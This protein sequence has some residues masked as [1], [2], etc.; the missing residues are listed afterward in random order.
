MTPIVYKLVDRAAWHSA[1][2][3]DLFAGIGRQSAR[4][5]HPLLERRQVARRSGAPFRR[6]GG[7]VARRRGRPGARARPA[8]GAVTGR[9]PVSAPLRP[10]RWRRCDCV[11]WNR[12]VGMAGAM[13]SFPRAASPS[14]PPP[15]RHFWLG[16]SLVKQAAAWAAILDAAPSTESMRA[17]EFTAHDEDAMSDL[18]R[19]LRLLRTSPLFTVTS[20]SSSRSG[21]APRRRSS[22]SSTRCSCGRCRSRIRGGWCRSRKRTTRCGPGAFGV[23]ALNYLSWTERRAASPTSARSGLGTYTLTGQGDPETYPG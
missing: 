21:S 12:A 7:P 4:R 17:P 20:S 19:A 10:C 8:L 23:S 1:E 13:A 3:A 14:T 6:P 2:S 16:A 22:A 11:A 18:R 5:V 15:V 9:R